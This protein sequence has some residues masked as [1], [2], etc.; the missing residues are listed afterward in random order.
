M[1][2]KQNISE[3]EIIEN[4][5]TNSFTAFSLYRVSEKQVRN[6]AFILK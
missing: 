3:T 6:F 1:V 2:S 4:N 5:F